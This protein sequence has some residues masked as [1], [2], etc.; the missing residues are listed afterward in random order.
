MVSMPSV[1][2]KEET[3]HA[4]QP[5]L[6]QRCQPRAESLPHQERQAV[7]GIQPINHAVA[8][9]S[10]HRGQNKIVKNCTRNKIGVPG[11]SRRQCLIGLAGF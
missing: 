9:A 7:L 4:Q 1:G 10:E 8:D 3:E 6:R 2:M 11:P 5:S